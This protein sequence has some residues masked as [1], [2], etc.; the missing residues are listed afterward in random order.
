MQ[1]IKRKLVEICLILDL[2]TCMSCTMLLRPD[3]TFFVSDVADLLRNVHFFF[4]G[5]ALRSSE[6]R[7][8]QTKHGK[9]HQRFIKHLSSRWL[10]LLDSTNRFLDEWAV[11]Y[12]YFFSH[13]PKKRK[14][15]LD[16]VV[17]KNISRHLKCG[18]FKGNIEIV[19]FCISTKITKFQPSCT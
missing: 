8:I 9:P 10:T 5:E 4:D 3:W 6:Y 1:N 13:I 16:A 18:T 11:A 17:Y 19:C 14:S 15:T 7:D 12:E 2:V